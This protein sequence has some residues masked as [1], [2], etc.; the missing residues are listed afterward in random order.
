VHDPEARRR[1]L[2]RGRSAEGFV[3]E[4]LGAAGV[5]VLA[6]NW[7][8]GGGELDLVVRRDGRIRFVEVK[9]R[10]DD[11]VDPLEAIGPGKRSRLVGAAEAWLSA[12]PSH[13][14]ESSELAF[15]VAVVDL[16]TEPWSV[17]WLDSAFDGS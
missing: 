5:E 9:A 14:A 7:V 4:S 6:R 1:A 10:A 2:D 17:A 15:L 16:A 12:H 11:G 8:G 13:A 3:A